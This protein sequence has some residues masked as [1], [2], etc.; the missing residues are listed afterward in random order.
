MRLDRSQEPA[1]VAALA[2]AIGERV[3]RPWTVM[4]VCG[5]QT[6]T[7]VRQGLDQLLPPELEIVHGPGCPVCVTPIEVIDH[8][9]EI[10]RRPGVVLCSFGDMLRV[11]GSRDDLLRARAEGADVRVVYSPIDVVRLAVAEPDREVVFLA[12]G[13]ETTAPAVAAAVLEAARLGLAN[14]SVLVAHVLVPP[15]LQAVLEAPDNRVQGFLGPGHVCTV[16][17][18]VDYEPIARQHRVPIVVT[19]FEPTDLLE[20]LLLLV[21]QLEDG[22]HEV[23]NQYGRAARRLGNEA[24]QRAVGEVF[25]PV[26][27]SWRGLGVLPASGFGLRASY[28]AFD[29][30]LRYP[31]EGQPA[32]ESTDCQAGLVLQGRLRPDECA[33]FGS[34][35]T[36]EHPLG[37]PM[38]STEGACAAYHAAGRGQVAR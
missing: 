31:R 23:E 9:L 1:A 28:A 33:A 30:A 20:G 21:A 8:A 11:P 13:F 5:G 16:V 10:A 7:F 34:A 14:L 17:G 36:P 27:R 22:R 2:R 26:D 24:A 15:A 6:H 12:V 37:A 25:E 32:P 3:T 38:V 19:G 29:A 35:C 18:W 4:E